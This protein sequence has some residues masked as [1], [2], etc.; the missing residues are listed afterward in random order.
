VSG[1]SLKLY[2]EEDV[3]YQPLCN[4][5]RDNDH[6]IV[7]LENMIGKYQVVTEVL[8]TRSREAIFSGLLYV[9]D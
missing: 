6:D 4:A 9:I 1:Y 3:W 7:I 5:A 2:A 8:D